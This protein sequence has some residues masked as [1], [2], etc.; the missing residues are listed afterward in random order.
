MKISRVDFN[1][2]TFGITQKSLKMLRD[3]LA[4]KLKHYIVV[5]KVPTSNLC[6]G[7]FIFDWDAQ[8]VTWTGDG[9]RL[10]GAGEGGAG[11]KSAQS[12]FTLYDIIPVSWETVNF[13]EIYSGVD[14]NKIGNFL[15]NLARDIVND[16]DDSLFYIP[17]DRSP[18][19]IR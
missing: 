1:E 3:T 11:Y 16:L 6:C 7:Y 8:D 4:A 15:F 10:D 9:F 5:A 13:E 2:D 18:K 17:A 12:L 14:K 19:Y